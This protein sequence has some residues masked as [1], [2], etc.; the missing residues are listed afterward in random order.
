[1]PSLPNSYEPDNA[2]GVEHYLSAGPAGLNDYDATTVAYH[3]V[4]E[5]DIT[6]CKRQVQRC[7]VAFKL[8]KVKR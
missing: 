5:T 6:S 7:L 1:M 4:C 8:C 3:Y 2:G